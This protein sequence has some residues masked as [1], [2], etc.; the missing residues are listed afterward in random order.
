M[1]L[2]VLELMYFGVCLYR[3]CSVCVCVY[4]YLCINIYIYIGV[5]V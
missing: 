4:I 2:Y 5:C 1:C 3:I